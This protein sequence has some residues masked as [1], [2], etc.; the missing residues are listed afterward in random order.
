MEDAQNVL[1]EGISP[2]QDVQMKINPYALMEHLI[3]HVPMEINQLVQMELY[4]KDL[5]AKM[6]I[7]RLVLMDPL[8]KNQEKPTVTM[9][10]NQAV[11][12]AI[13]PYVLMERKP[14]HVLMGVDRSVWMRA[15][16]CV[17]MG[18]AP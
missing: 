15:E 13:A 3:L 4:F 9:V 6:E 18:Q 1:M 16:L 17:L 12:M 11:L 2:G 14:H 5:L 8:L 10:E 7:D